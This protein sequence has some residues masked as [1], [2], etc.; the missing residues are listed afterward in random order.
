MNQQYGYITFKSVSY[1]MKFET[2][3]KNYEIKIKIIPVPRSISSSCGL[4]GR[5]NLD[6]LDELKAL[7]IKD[8]LE[9]DNIYTNI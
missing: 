3:M 4:C 7:M 6:E 5:F 1:A 2:A 9:Y 8:N